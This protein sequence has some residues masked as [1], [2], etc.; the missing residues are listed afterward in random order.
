[1]AS[2]YNSPPSLDLSSTNWYLACARFSTIYQ[3]EAKCGRESIWGR[4][5]KLQNVHVGRH[6]SKMLSDRSKKSSSELNTIWGRGFYYEKNRV[7]DIL[8]VLSSLYL[9]ARFVKWGK[10]TNDKAA[11]EGSGWKC[12]YSTPWTTSRPHVLICTS[13]HAL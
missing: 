4:S 11:V 7:L 2:L 5:F 8:F 13:A 12:I 3:R 9:D 10:P 6:L 1:M